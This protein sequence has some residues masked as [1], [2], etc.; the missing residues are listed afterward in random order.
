MTDMAKAQTYI[1][2]VNWNGWRDTIECL[3]SLLRQ[4]NGAF[5][6]VICDNGSTDGSVDKI[7]QWASG[8]LAAERSDA[9]L[10]ESGGRIW[11]LTFKINQRDESIH[12]DCS[13]RISLIEA[14][15]NIGFA[16]GNNLGIVQA[17]ADPDCEFIWLLNNDTVVDRHALDEQIKVMQSKPDVAICGSTICY[18]DRPRTVQGLGGFYNIRRAEGRHLFAYSSVD[19]L[20]PV[21]EVEPLM[22]YVMGASMLVRR[23]IFE[24][25][26]GLSEDYFLYFEEID[27]AQKLTKSEAQSWSPTSLVYHKEG[28]SIG[29][30]STNRPSNTSIYYLNVNILRFYWRFHRRSILSAFSRVAFHTAGYLIK[31]DFSGAKIST[32]AV[33]E[34][35]TRRRRIGKVT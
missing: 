4:N 3:E 30:S 1:I 9:V 27:L 14:R 28:S 16:A 17:L 20:P 26:Q 18:Y 29:S 6:V 22:T 10:G 7:T 19:R 35:L 32:L 15:D 11:P 8:T 31:R 21:E 24:R 23:N 34:F 5:R 2:L 13:P 25:T 33:F 12:L